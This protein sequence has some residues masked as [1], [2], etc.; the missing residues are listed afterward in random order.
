M[1]EFESVSELMEYIYK[2][3][4]VEFRENLQALIQ[5]KE[6]EIYIAKIIV[7]EGYRCKGIGT[8]YILELIEYAK[9]Y[10]KRLTLIPSSAYGGNLRRLKKFYKKLGF[11]HIGHDEWCYF[12]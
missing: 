7:A 5:E 2:D 9:K 4:Y 11:V 6:H 1:G 3:E 10:N 12:S 8:K